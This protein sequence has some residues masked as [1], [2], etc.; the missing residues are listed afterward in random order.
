MNVRNK[1]ATEYIRIA[2]RANMGNYWIVELA[3]MQSVER[4]IFD[5]KDAI[6][7][8]SIFYSL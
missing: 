3:L 7:I 8:Y 4:N 1:N 6:K 5:F 2:Y